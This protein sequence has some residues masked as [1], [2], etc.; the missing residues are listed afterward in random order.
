MAALSSPSAFDVIAPALQHTRQQLRSFVWG[1]WW[2][3][4]VLGFLTGE[5]GSFGCG[6]R[7][8]PPSPAP[9]SS[10]IAWPDESLPVI[11]MAATMIGLVIC[12]VVVAITYINSI[13]RFV[14]IEA[15]VSRRVEGI[16]AGWRKWRSVGQQFFY[17]QIA[18]QGAVLASLAVVVGAAFAVASAAGWAADPQAHAAALALCV[19]VT[20]TLGVTLLL[21]AVVVYVTA[22]DFVAPIMAVE[23]VG[24]ADAWRRA[25]AIAGEDRWGFASY[26]FV[27]VLLSIAGL[28]LLVAAALAVIVPVVALGGLLYAVGPQ[29]GDALGGVWMATL[30]GAA[31]GAFIVL[32]VLFFVANV[33]FVVFFPAYGL[34]FLAARYRELDPWLTPDLHGVP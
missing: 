30:A 2:R 8:G 28:V 15:V 26:F 23:Q 3:L 6:G 34:Y 31:V 33:P 27:K 22:K 9:P 12:A 20:G 21:I 25:L 10:E 24:V 14:L 1:Q 11:L 5:L 17:W 13:C 32:A 19:A 16:R 29:S 4:A 7:G 18:F